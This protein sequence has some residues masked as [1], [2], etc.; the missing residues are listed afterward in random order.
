MA[1][2][3][4]STTKLRRQPKRQRQIERV[5]KLAE[6]YRALNDPTSAA[7]LEDLALQAEWEDAATATGRRK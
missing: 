5:W 7:W 3:K 2:T 4:N 6:H 1:A